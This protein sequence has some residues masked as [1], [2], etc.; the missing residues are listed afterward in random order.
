M[1]LIPVYLHVR[2]AYNNDL[3]L[4]SALWSDLNGLSVELLTQLHILNHSMDTRIKIKS[5]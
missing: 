2:G 3:S 4:S 1:L 5:R